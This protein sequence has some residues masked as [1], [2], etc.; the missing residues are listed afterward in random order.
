MMSCFFSFSGHYGGASFSSIMML[1]EAS[2]VGRIAQGASSPNSNCNGSV[3][4]DIPSIRFLYLHGTWNESLKSTMINMA[5]NGK[6][7]DRKIL[8]FTSRKAGAISS[9]DFH[10]TGEQLISAGEVRLTTIGCA[11]FLQ[12]L[13]P[14][15]G[16]TEVSWEIMCACLSRLET[17]RFVVWWC[18]AATGWIANLESSW[19][20]LDARGQ[21]LWMTYKKR[22]K[23]LETSLNHRNFL[24]LS[25]VHLQ[26]QMN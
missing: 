23:S 11:N 3:R 2:S 19:G 12:T 20:S 21:K 8:W 1:M 18:C 15:V 22:K 25:D 5:F 9:I 24:S 4:T 7:R 10:P 13:T 26:I 14:K 6:R 16:K 17:I